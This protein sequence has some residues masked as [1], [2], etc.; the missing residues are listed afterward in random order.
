[1]GLKPTLNSFEGDRTAPS[2]K[3][4]DATRS[5]M[6]VRGVIWYQFLTYKGTYS[7]IKSI[8]PPLLIIMT[9]HS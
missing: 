9:L 7:N 6:L 4:Q 2:L 8:F 5:T 3:E 1:M